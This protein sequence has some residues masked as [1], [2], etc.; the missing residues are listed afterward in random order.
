VDVFAMGKATTGCVLDTPLAP[1][2]RPLDTAQSWPW[3][4]RR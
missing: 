4:V 1:L 2:G 3:I